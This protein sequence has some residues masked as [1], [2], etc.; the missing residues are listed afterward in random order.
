MDI[1]TKQDRQF[2][3]Q[4]KHI[5]DRSTEIV[6]KFRTPTEMQVSVL[7]DFD[8]PTPDA[9][10]WQLQREVTVQYQE[11]KHA[12]FE[13]RKILLD[14]RKLKL[15]QNMLKVDGKFNNELDEI[16]YLKKQVEI[17]EKEFGLENLKK[18]TAARVEELRN[19]KTIQS[20]LKPQLEYSD[21]DP[22]QH[23]FISYARKFIMQAVALPHSKASAAEAK[24]ILGHLYTTVKLA[25]RKGLLN[26]IVEPFGNNPNI[27]N[28][29]SDVT[30]QIGN[31]KPKLKVAKRKRIV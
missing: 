26:K 17:E 13:A 25:K 20:S 1:L 8:N 3:E 19:W 16:E 23:Q 30:K 5:F 7:N 28:L 12:E 21:S 31:E 29:I 9:K 27:L 4:N 14:I 22:D 11:I 15:E 10:Y 24:N 2:L 6:Q 18:M